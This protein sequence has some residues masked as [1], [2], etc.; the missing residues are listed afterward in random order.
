MKTNDSRINPAVAA[1]GIAL[2]VITAWG[3]FLY[4]NFPAYL[5]VFMI[6]LLGYA[7][8]KTAEFKNLRLYGFSAVFSFLLSASFLI[9]GKA[10]GTSSRL[11]SP[12]IL[13]FFAMVVAF[14]FF[15]SWLGGL[16][17]RHPINLTGKT[18]LKPRTVWLVCTLLLFVSW[19]P[20]LFVYYPGSVSADSLACVVRAVGKAGLSNQQPVLYILMMR[21][22]FQ[23]ALSI[24]KSM[25]FGT[26]L[27]LL[28]QAAS[29]A[30][31]LGYFPCW[32]AKKGYPLWTVC[33]TM[34]YFM[35]DPVFP[36]YSVTMWK[37]VPFSALLAVYVLNVLDILQSKGEWL[38]NKRS[39]VW[40]LLLNVLIAF[41]RNNGYYIIFVT[42]IALAIVYRKNW[43]R[44]VPAFLAILVI[45]PVVQGPVYNVCG[46]R[47]SPFA[48][49]VGI[50]LQ[51]IGRTVAKGGKLTPE[52]SEFLN[53][54]IPLDE[55]KKTYK[56]NTAD[57]IKFN[58]KFN[59]VFL[60]KNKGQFLK[61][62][63]QMMGPNI[64]YY[65]EAWALETLGYWHVG[66]T[67]WVLFYGIGEN[68]GAQLSGL[69]MS[70]L[71]NLENNR[72]SIQQ[73]FDNLQKNVPVLSLLVNIGF[74]FWAAVFSAML[75]AV[76]KKG[77]LLLAY[78]PLL[79]LWGVLMLATPTSCEF[80]YM[81][82]FAIVFPAM[83]VL[84]FPTKSAARPE[85]VRGKAKAAVPQ[86]NAVSPA[87]AGAAVR[88]A[89]K[90]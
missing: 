3:L 39:F 30:V 28:L 2:D 85:H 29:T 10:A 5:L 8:K 70:N 1:V 20:C 24:G 81:F 72:D 74:L 88:P 58:T 47:Q 45:V 23:F 64:R 9:G 43:K 25:N 13:C 51:Q 54:V 78:L 67:N 48:E 37:D 55:M 42:L 17:L 16:I 90:K 6:A 57:G 80:R 63:L 49:S 36:M 79:V 83:I 18:T 44:L 84:A 68:Y 32:L 14:F 40:F 26:A 12:G 82:T 4:F 7:M 50:P 38:G 52:Q 76:Q 66:T 22:F 27:F 41:M 19:I 61:V 65:G 56:S 73:A 69:S 77:K 75:L 59:N 89:V 33:L 62:W 31:L 87:A 34:A 71:W 53:H 60:E 15:T 86:R 46:I 11:Y 35:L 21:P